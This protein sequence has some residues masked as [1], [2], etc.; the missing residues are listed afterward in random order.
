MSYIDIQRCKHDYICL[1][2]LKKY[3]DDIIIPFY[4]KKIIEIC[5]YFCRKR[6]LIKFKTE[7]N[8]SKGS[9]NSINRAIFETITDVI[10]SDV[11]EVGVKQSYIN[12]EDLYKDLDIEIEELYDLYTNY[13]DN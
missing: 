6:E 1:Q 8:K 4:S 3:S 11:L 5:E 2:E 12:I 10:F 7:R 13:L 9:S